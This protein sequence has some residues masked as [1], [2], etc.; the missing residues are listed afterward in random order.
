MAKTRG[1]TD[2]SERE[3]TDASDDA[4]QATADA[5]CPERTCAKCNKSFV[6][7]K[8]GTSRKNC[9]QCHKPWSKGAPS[10]TAGLTRTAIRVSA[11]IYEVAQQ[12]RGF[13]LKEPAFVHRKPA[14]D[15][16]PHA[17]RAFSASDFEALIGKIWA[18]MEGSLTARSQ[19]SSTVSD[20]AAGFACD[21]WAACEDGGDIKHEWD[22]ICAHTAVDAG[23]SS[24]QVSELLSD[25][26]QRLLLNV[27]ADHVEELFHSACSSH[28]KSLQ[29]P[30]E[31]PELTSAEQQT[32]YYCTGWMCRKLREDVEKSSNMYLKE[33][34]EAMAIKPME[35]KLAGLPVEKV[36]CMD[37]GGLVFA[38]KP[39]FDFIQRTE[40]IFKSFRSLEAA[41]SLGCGA[42]HLLDRTIA[43]AK[44]DPALHA[45]AAA[46]LGFDDECQDL[47]A[48]M[49][50]LHLVLD[51]YSHLSKRDLARVIAEQRA[52]ASGQIKS[53]GEQKSL[54][55]G[56][57][58]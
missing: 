34:V 26:Q 7:Q 5:T 45:L 6:L 17:I 13:L 29:L 46:A 16:Y 21:W 57:M 56:L 35:A 30:D 41:S 39:V 44:S 51:R 47:E 25:H 22:E 27:L 42:T 28:S 37:F 15:A 12:V 9:Y 3:P 20:A 14:S 49:V 58:K 19:S 38:A 10:S 2:T 23:G 48:S 55:G 50:L 31:L 24:L 54:R 43:A 33:A 40:Q 11:V 18:M 52:I 36:Q 32:I 8:A 4:P 1:G 53:K